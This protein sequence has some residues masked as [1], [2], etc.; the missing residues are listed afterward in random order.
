ML[1]PLDLLENLE[2]RVKKEKWE[3]EVLVEQE[4]WSDPLVLR[5]REEDLVEMEKEAYLGHLDRRES[6]ACKDSLDW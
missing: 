5:E 4:V 2:L 6:R 3:K 1:V